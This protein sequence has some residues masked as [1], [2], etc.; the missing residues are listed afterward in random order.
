MGPYPF[1]GPVHPAVTQSGGILG[2]LFAIGLAVVAIGI[3]TGVSIRWKS[4]S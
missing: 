1:Y 2:V 3:V 4:P